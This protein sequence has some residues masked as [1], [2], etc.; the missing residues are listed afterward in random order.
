MVGSFAACFA[1]AGL[2]PITAAT[3][4]SVMN[5]RRFMFIP[6]QGECRTGHPAGLTAN[7]EVT[8]A[9]LL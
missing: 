5:W 1:R 9:F 4:T 2:G 3:P 7:L 6:T 8:S